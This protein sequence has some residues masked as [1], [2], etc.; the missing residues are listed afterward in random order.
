MSI[1]PEELRLGHV[2]NTIRAVQAWKAELTNVNVTPESVAA[3]YGDYAEL[4]GTLAT[5]SVFTGSERA[6]YFKRLLDQTFDGKINVI[7][8]T[9]AANRDFTGC[10]GDYTFSFLNKDREKTKLHG[11]FE[12]KANKPDD[13]VTYHH[14][15]KANE[16]PDELSLQ[17]C[18]NYKD[19][20]DGEPDALDSINLG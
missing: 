20:E 11:T 2:H 5:E 15:Y 3:I 4:K 10:A 7:F 12:F 14:S 6:A 16:T 8:N 19:F 17:L 1:K 9:I 13:K 18:T